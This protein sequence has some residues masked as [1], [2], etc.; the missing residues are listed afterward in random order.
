MKHYICDVGNWIYNGM[1]CWSKW[2]ASMVLKGGLN[3]YWERFSFLANVNE[4]CWL[5]V[6][7]SILFDFNTCKIL[8]LWCWKFVLWW[9][10][11]LEQT[12]GLHDVI[13]WFKYIWECFTFIANVNE[14]CWLEVKNSIFFDLNTCKILQLWCWKLDL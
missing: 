3:T 6:I 13:R 7:N 8:Y 14:Y 5:D 9:V 1:L 11:L 10:V 2:V 4:Y 12:C